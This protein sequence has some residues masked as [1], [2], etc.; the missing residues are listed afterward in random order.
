MPVVEGVYDL[1]HLSDAEEIFLTSARLGVALVTT[2]DFHRYT[3]P[4]A[5]VALRLRA[6]LRDLMYRDPNA[7]DAREDVRY[8]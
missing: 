8:A 3:V 6:A 2:Y 7:D 4:V 1:A 5:S